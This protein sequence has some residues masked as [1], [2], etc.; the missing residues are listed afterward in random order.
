MLCDFN[1]STSFAIRIVLCPSW[2][3]SVLLSNCENYTTIFSKNQQPSL[4]KNSILSHRGGHMWLE[5]LRELRKEKNDISYKTI[6]ERAKVSEKTVSR[7]FHGEVDP[8]L[9]TLDRIVTSL[10]STLS[11]IFEDTKAVVVD[12]CAIKTQE[13]FD[14]LTAERDLVVAENVILKDK[15]AV[16]TAEID[17]LKMKLAH[18]EE[19]IAL[20]NYYNKMMPTKE[21]K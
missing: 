21:E 10:D 5:K 11:E 19:I 16:M 17:L 9:D 15:V 8:Y 3:I 12:K 4:A 6:A 2:I 14:V 7:V 13:E 18:K 1:R 20:H